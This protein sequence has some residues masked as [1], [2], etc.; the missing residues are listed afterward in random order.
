[1]GQPS[2]LLWYVGVEI[3]LTSKEGRKS[4]GEH[5][6]EIPIGRYRVILYRECCITWSLMVHAGVIA[7][8]T[9]D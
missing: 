3:D 6:A 8:D 1:M 4:N 5:Y 9:S 7:L 2:V